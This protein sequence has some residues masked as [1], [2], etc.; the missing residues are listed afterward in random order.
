MLNVKKFGAIGDGKT[1]DTAAVQSALDAAEKTK[2]SLYIPEG[3]YLCGELYIHSNT[4]ITLN[5]NAV[6][7]A[8]CNPSDYPSSKNKKPM[9][10]FLNIENAENV[11]IS[12]GQLRTTDEVFWQFQHPLSEKFEPCITAE[13]WFYTKAKPWRF[14]MLDA[15]DS[16]NIKISGVSC[17]SYPCYAYNFK[18]CFDISI[19]D[20][21]IRGK[22][23]GINTDGIHLSSCQNVTIRSCNI[24]CGD[25]C[26]AIDSDHGEKGNN[27]VIS[28][29][30]LET[31]VHAFRFYVGLDGTPDWHPTL[32]NIAVSNCTVADAAGIFDINAR[33]GRI[34]N[35]SVNNITATQTRPGNAFVIS[36]IEGKVD[37]VLLSGL[38]VN[39][40]GCG[41][42]SS[43]KMGEIENI[44]LANSVFHIT[45]SPKHYLPD[46]LINEGYNFPNHCH[47]KPVN[48]YLYQARDVYLS[49]VSVSWEKGQFTDGW[50]PERREKLKAMITPTTLDQMESKQ[51][52]AVD[53]FESTVHYDGC[54]LPAYYDSDY[55]A[56]V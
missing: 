50:T 16:H 28:D 23:Y 24:R 45:P 56:N 54:S 52:E 29:C 37:S 27:F 18:R 9:R 22:T 11:Y 32:S 33:K 13:A 1:N 5:R 47:F 7:V 30:I 48:F 42:I 43:D 26:I 14:H 12:G 31:S 36:T 6:L 19:S 51:F 55:V 39:G 41:M 17:T 34:F 46:R 44:H 10:G 4:S 35:I 8:S 25:D 3:E 15:T 49:N 21:F 20:L 38:M 2:E 53:N 40:N